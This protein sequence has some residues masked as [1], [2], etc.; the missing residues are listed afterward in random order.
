[1][2]CYRCGMEGHRERD[3]LIAAIDNGDKPPWCGICDPNSRLVG[4]ASGIPIRCPDCHPFRGQQLKQFKR[5][6]GC[7]M[8]IHEWD[9]SPCGSHSSRQAP[10]QRLTREHID[11]I[12]TSEGGTS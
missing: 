5:C 1:M 9:T 4:N 11:Q 3:C 2:Q 10:D 8:Q 6:P 12:V 7:K